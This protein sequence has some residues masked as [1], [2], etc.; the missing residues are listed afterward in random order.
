MQPTD[1]RRR[2]RREENLSLLTKKSKPLSNVLERDNILTGCNSK[3]RSFMYNSWG[4]AMFPRATPVGWLSEHCTAL[5]SNCHPQA[6]GWAH[7]LRI[8]AT[9]LSICTQAPAFFLSN[10][11]LLWPSLS[12][13]LVPPLPSVVV[14]CEDRAEAQSFGVRDKGRRRILLVGR[15]WLNWLQRVKHT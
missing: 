6:L 3:T 10:G 9:S 13:L 1:K 7:I 11:Y 8:S 12:S 5:I 15:Q 2:K 4:E 14:W